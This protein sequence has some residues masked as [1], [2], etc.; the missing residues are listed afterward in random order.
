[1]SSRHHARQAQLRQMLRH[2]S[3][4]LVDDVG[5][6]VHRQLAVF[7]QREDDPD[8][9]GIREHREHL[10]REFDVLAVGQSAAT[11]RICIHTQIIAQWQGRDQRMPQLAFLEPTRNDG[12]TW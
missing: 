6:V 2:G 11:L 8:S 5:E 9:R 7:L 3:R 4:C 10:D 12:A 1:L